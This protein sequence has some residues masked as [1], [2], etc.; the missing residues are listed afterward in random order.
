[1]LNFILRC[2]QFFEKILTALQTTFVKKKGV[3]WFKKQLTVFQRCELSNKD[4]NNNNITFTKLLLY[5]DENIK[6]K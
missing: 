2:L 3:N 1:M 5:L 4:I 6:N